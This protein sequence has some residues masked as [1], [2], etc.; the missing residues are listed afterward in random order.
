[1]F[2]CKYYFPSRW[3]DTDEK[4]SQTELRDLW[5]TYLKRKYDYLR[6]HGDSNQR[7][8]YA[9]KVAQELCSLFIGKDRIVF[10]MEDP[11]ADL[12]L[13]P[14]AARRRSRVPAPPHLQRLLKLKFTQELWVIVTEIFSK[15]QCKTWALPLL[16]WFIQNEEEVVGHLGAV[17]ETRECWA[18]FCGRLCLAR[19]PCDM[20][21]FWDG[22]PLHTKKERTWEWSSDVKGITWME[23]VKRWQF[24][25]NQWEMGVMLL[26][27]PFRY[28]L[29]CFRLIVS[30]LI[31][32]FLDHHLFG[33]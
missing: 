27:V 20:D 15:E 17:D 1:M 28:V 9:K 23:F 25:E 29:T 30:T 10:K 16:T 22:K 6:E 3:R 5:R 26:S 32:L 31:L 11:D 13:S 7:K 19:D 18:S 4:H 24:G 33:N 12:L 14:S 8:V 2:T 21:V